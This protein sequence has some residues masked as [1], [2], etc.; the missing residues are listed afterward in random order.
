MKKKKLIKKI[1]KVLQSAASPILK[2]NDIEALIRAY[3]EEKKKSKIN[4]K[5]ELKNMK[6]LSDL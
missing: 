5:K 1:E 6:G 4:F 3:K 2:V